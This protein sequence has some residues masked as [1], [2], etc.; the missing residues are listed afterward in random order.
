[1]HPLLL[2]FRDQCCRS[3]SGGRLC[4][5]RIVIIPKKILVLKKRADLQ[6]WTKYMN[7]KKNKKNNTPVW[8][9]IKSVHS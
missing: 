7:E 4:D 6:N 1:M 2:T 5:F 8:R 3:T 9:P